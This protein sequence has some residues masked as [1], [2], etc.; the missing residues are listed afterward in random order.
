MLRL[1]SSIHDYQRSV[2]HLSNSTVVRTEAQR[3]RWERVQ[4]VRTSLLD[5]ENDLLTLTKRD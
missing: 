1:L 5:A 2:V 3:L 4:R